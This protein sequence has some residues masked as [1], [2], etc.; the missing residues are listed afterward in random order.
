VAAG[1]AFASQYLGDGAVTLCFLGEG[2]MHIGATHEGMNLAGL[3]RLPIVF[4]IENNQYAMGTPLRRQTAV[5]DLTVRA[6]AYRLVSD[7]WV[8]RDIFE[9]RERLR[10]AV[11]RARNE[12]QPCLIELLTYRFRGHSMSDPGKYRQKDEIEQW[13][14][15]DPLFRC[16]Q[17][18]QSDYGMSEDDLTAIDDRVIE[19]MEQ[20]VQFAEESPEPDPEHRFRNH[21]VED[22][23]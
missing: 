10:R 16:E 4:V 3:W 6:P 13:R 5:A 19:E 18:L 23:R 7:R 8:V 1:H 12:R 11:H 20:A 2:A 22:D 17:S 9:T 14:Q 21:Y 15:R